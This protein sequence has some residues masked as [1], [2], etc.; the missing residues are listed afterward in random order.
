MLKPLPLALA[1]LLGVSNLVFAQDKPAR[2]KPEDTEAWT[3]VP[4]VVQPGPYKETPAPEGAIILFDGKNLD[5]WINTGNRKPADWILKDG[6]LV[7]NKKTGNIETKRKFKDYQLH[8]E[9]LFPDNSEFKG[10]A[11]SNSGLFLAST[12]GGDAGYELQILDSHQNETY[13]NGM[14]ASIYKQAIPLANPSRKPGEWQTYDVTWT[15]PRF[16]SD[17]SLESPATVTVLFNGVLVQDRFVL[18]GETAFIGQP[19]YKPYDTAAIKLQSH[20]DGSK[21]MSFR[22]IWIKET[23]K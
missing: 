18:K 22:N 11:R 7:V 16:K 19:K 13:V 12:G 2:P 10:Q 4:P 1:A 5:E 21:P 15:A 20:G 17:G 9:F 6:V 3:P 8:L 14:A 23:G